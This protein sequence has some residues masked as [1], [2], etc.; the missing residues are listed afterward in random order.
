[1]VLLI[2][3]KVQDSRVVS[4]NEEGANLDRLP[5]FEDRQQAREQNRPP[6]VQKTS[7]A[8]FI[9]SRSKNV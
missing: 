3:A 5:L 2:I 8:N 1:M 4:G 6:R 7:S 9:Q